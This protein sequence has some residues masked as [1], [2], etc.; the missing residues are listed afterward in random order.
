MRRT[1]ISV[2]T[3]GVAAKHPDLSR[4]STKSMSENVESGG[5]LKHHASVHPDLLP[6][7]SG[8]GGGGFTGQERRAGGGV[9]SGEESTRMHAFQTT[10]SVKHITF[11]QTGK[12]IAVASIAPIVTTIINVTTTTT[13]IIIVT[14]IT[15]IATMTTI[16]IIIST[17]VINF[18][19]ACQQDRTVV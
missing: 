7:R 5:G 11:P 8:S 14:T 19:P 2:T 9:Q 4:Y 12:C 6:A 10:S 1:A 18:M 17:T 15:T 13:I 3:R 16:V